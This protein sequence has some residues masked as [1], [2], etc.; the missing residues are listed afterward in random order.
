MGLNK[1]DVARIKK[2]AESEDSIVVAIVKYNWLECLFH[3]FYGILFFLFLVVSILVIALG[4]EFWSL[5]PGVLCLFCWAEAWLNSN[6]KLKSRIYTEKLEAYL[7]K[8][9]KIAE[10]FM[11]KCFNHHSDSIECIT[12]NGEK[13]MY[14]VEFL[15][16]QLPLYVVRIHLEVVS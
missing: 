10:P 5:I 4:Y 7:L 9:G 13:Q 1:K 16:E 2:I 3:S 11:T 15:Q 6:D 14:K 8:R 12:A